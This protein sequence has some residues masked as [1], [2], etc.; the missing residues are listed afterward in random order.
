MPRMLASVDLIKRG[1]EGRDIIRD[2]ANADSVDNT[3]HFTSE[4][5][6]VV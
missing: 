2:G 6:T 5:S 1:E 3:F 4:L